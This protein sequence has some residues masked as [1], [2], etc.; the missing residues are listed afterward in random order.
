MSSSQPHQPIQLRRQDLTPVARGCAEFIIHSIIPTGNKSEI[1]IPRAILIHSIIKGEDVRVE[2]LI[3][4]NIAICVEGVQGKLIF[5][6]TI[7]RLCKEAGVPFGEFK[8][9]KY[10]PIEKPITVRVMVRTRG[11]NANYIQEQHMEEEDYMQPDYNVAEYE[12]EQEHEQ[13]EVD[14]EARNQH[15]AAPNNEFFN[16]FQEQQ[17]QNFQQMN[18]QFSNMQLQQMQFFEN[19]QKIQAQYLEKLKGLKTKQDE[20]YTEQNNFYRQIRKEQGEMAKEIEEIKK[21]QSKNASSRE[22]YSG[23]AHQQANPNLVEMPIHKIPDLV[24]ENAANG[25]HIFYGALKSHTTQGGLSQ[26]SQPSKPT[27]TPM[28]DAEKE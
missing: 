5:P 9:T 28:E 14:F 22:A 23:W 18:E 24:H 11:R 1:T 10:I 27:D 4:D 6:S 21:F 8:G 19:M 17:Q 2:E 3:S 7:F 20:M 13:P 16:N 15:Y 12:N 25:E 26:P